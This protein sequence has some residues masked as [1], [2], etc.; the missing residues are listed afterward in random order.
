VV[1][2]A[3]VSAVSRARAQPESDVPVVRFVTV[4]GV[5]QNLGALG[6]QFG[7]GGMWGFEAGYQPGWIGA[8]WS[9]SWSV[10]SWAVLL[11]GAF[12]SVDPTSVH[13]DVGF[14]EMNLGLRVRWPIG[15]RQPRFLIVDAGATA[16]R[17]SIPIP[18]SS[19]REYLGPFVGLGVEQLLLGRYMV[20]VEAR[21]G[22]LMSGPSGVT[23][24]VSLGFGSR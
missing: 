7:R 6:D 11:G 13:E 24:N 3:I 12:E 15:D 21:Y 18:P 23:V 2:V 17:A 5:R 14:T 4:I 1:S 22:L 19:S 10:P 20:G 9:V 16:M 8:A